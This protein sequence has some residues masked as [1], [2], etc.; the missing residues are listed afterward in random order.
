MAEANSRRSFPWV[1]MPPPAGSSHEATNRPAFSSRS[2]VNFGT[3]FILPDSKQAWQQNV[4]AA[5]HSAASHGLHRCQRQLFSARNRTFLIA[6]LI[7]CLI[8]ALGCHFID[9]AR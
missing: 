9:R 2:M 1:V 6:G 4:L 5:R 3:S 8:E 7:E